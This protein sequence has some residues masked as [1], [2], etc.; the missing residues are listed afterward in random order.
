MNYKFAFARLASVARFKVSGTCLP[1]GAAAVL[2]FSVKALAAAAATKR[3]DEFF[4]PVLKVSP[5]IFFI[6]SNT[7]P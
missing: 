6:H 1:R 3:R 7:Q 5:L 2:Y 4:A